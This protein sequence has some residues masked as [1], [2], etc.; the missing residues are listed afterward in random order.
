MK[1]L[2]Y[3]FHVSYDFYRL[4]MRASQVTYDVGKIAR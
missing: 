2:P 1:I 4:N 3:G